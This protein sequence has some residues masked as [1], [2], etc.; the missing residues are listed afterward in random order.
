MTEPL[1]CPQC[2]NEIPAGSSA[3]LCP[4]CLVLNEATRQR[5]QCVAASLFFVGLATLLIG[6]GIALWC[7]TA[8]V[9]ITCLPAS[10]SKRGTTVTITSPGTARYWWLLAEQFLAAG[11]GAVVTLAGASLRRLSFR[12]LVAAGSVMAMIPLSPAWLLS[13]PLGL[14]A[15]FVIRR[16]EVQA[17]FDRPPKIEGQAAWGGAPG[18]LRLREQLGTTGI[19]A[20]I[21]SL[22]GALATFLPWAVLSMFGLTILIFGC[23]IWYGI[24]AGPTFLAVFLVLVAAG[25]F[26]LRRFWLTLAMIVGGGVVVAATG[27]FLLKCASPP[28]VTTTVTTS[29]NAAGMGVEKAVVKPMVD[30]FR[31]GI[32]GGTWFGSWFA[33]CFGLG[34]LMLGCILIPCLC[35][36]P[37]TGGV[38]RLL[39]SLAPDQQVAGVTSDAAPAGVSDPDTKGKVP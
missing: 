26:R 33:L 30:M 6:L 9:Q 1:L 36:D 34:L 39:P 12:K 19:L 22:A 2:G 16:P 13:L 3:G 4:K 24:V 5:V 11:A 32:G 37:A 17:A 18:G 38:P 15:L 25:W 14:W 31:G 23:D 10:S 29:G 8:L 7:G 28:T 27:V 21:I 35:R 20:A